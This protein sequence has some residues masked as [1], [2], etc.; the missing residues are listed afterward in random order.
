MS[1]VPPCVVESCL[2]W[3][4][5]LCHSALAV[6]GSSAALLLCLRSSSWDLPFF[7]EGG[8]RYLCPL[9]PAVGVGGQAVVHPPPRALIRP[10]LRQQQLWHVCALSLLSV[11]VA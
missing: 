8:S 3:G 11:R 6:P 2:G 10:E 1:G 9:Q 7:A 4:L 5:I